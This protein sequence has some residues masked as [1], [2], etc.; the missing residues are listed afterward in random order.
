MGPCCSEN[1]DAPTTVTGAP[2][3]RYLHRAGIAA[4]KSSGLIRFTM[5]DYLSSFY[6]VL[7]EEMGESK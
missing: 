7:P 6:K 2:R 1:P 3:R 4:I 5:K